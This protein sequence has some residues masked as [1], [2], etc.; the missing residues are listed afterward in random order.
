MAEN[1]EQKLATSLTELRE[2]YETQVRMNRDEIETIYE[3]KVSFNVL[4]ML[5]KYALQNSLSD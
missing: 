2:Q 1:Y 5:T 3:T 4:C